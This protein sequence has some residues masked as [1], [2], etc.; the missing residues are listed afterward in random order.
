MEED[1]NTPAEKDLDLPEEIKDDNITAPAQPAIKS[2]DTAEPSSNIAEKIPDIPNEQQPAMEV[3]HHPNLH[4]NP[5]KI[6]EYVLE[7]I[8]IFLAVTMGFFA[9]NIRQNISD[10]WQ[11]RHLCEQLVHDLKNDSI[12]LDNNILRET[13]LAKK[14]DSLFSLLQQPATTLDSKKM[15]ELIIACYNINL[16]QPSSGAMSAIKNELHL[17]QFA[18]SDITLYISN[19]ETDQA[20]LKTIEQF[21][22]AN[23]KQYIQGFISTHFTPANAYSSLNNGPITGGELRNLAKNDLIQLSADLGFIKSYNAELLGV[24]S[25]LKLKASQFITYVNKEFSL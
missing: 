25:E 24:S 12:I 1:H 9:E 3:Y 6:K 16:F 21:H 19:Y 22:M 4:H 8:M 11:V 20:L 13:G 18:N 5:K 14:T 7:F 2:I 10:K 23:L 15:Q 17:K